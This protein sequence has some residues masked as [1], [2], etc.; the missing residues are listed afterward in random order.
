MKKGNVIMTKPSPRI[1]NMD[2]SEM[3]FMCIPNGRENK[4]KINKLIYRW[5]TT[6][7]LLVDMS[8]L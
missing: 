8:M 6:I 7:R 3:Y 4:N 5:I 2:K 1:F